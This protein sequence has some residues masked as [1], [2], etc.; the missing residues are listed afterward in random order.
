VSATPTTEPD[1]RTRCAA[2]LDHLEWLTLRDF[3]AVAGP[4][5]MVELHAAAH[6]WP[7]LERRAQLVLADVAGRRGDVAEQGR[8]AKR[9]NLW[10]AEHG[11]GFLLS[12][13]H[14]LLAIFFDRIG[15]AAEALGHA[16]AGIE[17]GDRLPPAL[18]CSQ[19]ISL[20]LLLDRNARQAEAR[21][22]FAEAL[23]IAETIDDPHLALTVL[24]NMAF[25]AYEN[26]DAAEAEELGRQMRA[27]AARAGVAVDGMILD[28]LARIFL[29]QGRYAEAEAALEPVL[30]DPEGPLVSEGDS[31]PECLL[32][33][34][35][36]QT[37][38]G[39]AEQA[40]ATL[41]EVARLC[42]ERGL[43]AVAARAHEA[44]AEWYAA[45]GRFAEA[46]AEYRVFHQRSEALHSVQREARAYALHAAYETAEARRISESFRELAHRDALTGLFNRRHVEEQLAAM[47]AHAKRSGEP[48]SVAI[49]D[50]DHFKRI[51]D[52][53]SHAA[54]DAV[55]RELGGILDRFVAG[56]ECAAR[57]GG[58]E[59]VLLLPGV[60]AGAAGQRCA[61]L[62]ARVRGADWRPVT[63]ELPVTASIGVT[64]YAGGPVSPAGLLA[65]ADDHLYAAKRAGRDR[66]MA[67]A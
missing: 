12:R 29:M 17:H 22:R 25:T 4:A 7:V 57:L 32:T 26:G 60:P 41:D 2:H 48:L 58:E 23:E 28:T 40:G 21:R 18:R 43:A 65:A 56:D 9:V 36:I 10:A 16:V 62:A 14:R 33:L 50:L 53:L 55:L 38:T 20:A 49:I 44:R 37:A 67:G 35:E 59:F 30:L 3:E 8:V 11:D 54:G 39:R 1:D 61:E 42:E 27:T 52:T 46:Y 66:V 13:S 31:L 47:T 15:D 64:T 5:A 63:G 45:A 24:N 6:G 51:N 34:A 19:L